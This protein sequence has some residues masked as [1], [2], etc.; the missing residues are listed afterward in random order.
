MIK[1]AKWAIDLNPY[2]YNSAAVDNN[3]MANCVIDNAKYLFNC[4]RPNAENKLINCIIS[5][6]ELFQQGDNTASFEYLNCDFYKDNF[7]TPSGTANMTVDPLFVD[8]AN[9]DY[10]LQSNSPCIDAGISTN[11]PS[12]DFEGNIRPQGIGYD[13]G[14]YEFSTITGVQNNGLKKISVFPNPT[15]QKIYLPQQYNAYKYQLF[16]S[17]GTLVKTGL[18]KNNEIDFSTFEIGIYTVRIFNDKTNIDKIIRIVK[19]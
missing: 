16:S 15:A 17:A 11:A 8:A 13:I 6:V 14:A 3:I 1:N 9:G 19:N 5:D 4:D 7:S 18:I 10:H 2:F 12:T